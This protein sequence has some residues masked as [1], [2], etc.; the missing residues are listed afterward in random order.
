MSILIQLHPVIKSLN[1]NNHEIKAS[2]GYNSIKKD[3]FTISTFFIH[4]KPIVPNH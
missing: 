2:I 3:K 1:K 4:S